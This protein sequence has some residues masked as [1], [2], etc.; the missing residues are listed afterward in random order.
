MKRGYGRIYCIQNKVDGKRYVGKTTKEC[1]QRLRGH[2]RFAEKRVGLGMEM[3]YLWKA[4]VKHGSENFTVR[5]LATAESEA[6]LSALEIKWIAE[7]GTMTPAGYNMHPGG[8]GGAAVGEALEKIKRSWTPARKER[9]AA[10]MVELHAQGHYPTPPCTP[11]IIEK[12]TATL[13]AN[14]TPESRARLSAQRRSEWLRPGQREKFSKRMR[15]INSS[16]EYRAKMRA[17][18]IA[19]CADQVWLDKRTMQ[20]WGSKYKLEAE[21]VVRK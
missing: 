7:L 8:E 15:E 14:M 21:Q 10:R 3:P 16:P 19:K 20:R 2:I 1:A 9:H 13:L 12:R 5:E 6:E 18:L 4:I 11:G 17:A